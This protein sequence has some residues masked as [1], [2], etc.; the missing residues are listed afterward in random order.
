MEGQSDTTIS[1]ELLQNIQSAVES[2]GL[3]GQVQLIETENGPMTVIIME[4]GAEG[5]GEATVDVS[6]AAGM[7]QPA[8]TEQQQQFQYEVVEDD[9]VSTQYLDTGQQSI[10]DTAVGS[11]VVSMETSSAT[12][13][14]GDTFQQSGVDSDTYFITDTGEIMKI[15]GSMINGSQIQHE[16]TV[17]Q[18]V[19]SVSQFPQEQ[20]FFQT[21]ETSTT[22]E[23]EPRET[24]IQTVDAFGQ[25]VS[26][27]VDTSVPPSVEQTVIQS[28]S[29]G[30]LPQ[31]QSV[32]ETINALNQL[33]QDQGSTQIANTAR[34]Q[35]SVPLA[36]STVLP[37]VVSSTDSPYTA[38]KLS[39]LVLQTPASI[40]SGQ[41]PVQKSLLSG[42]KTSQT[43][44][45]RTGS[46]Q[47]SLA[48]K[49]TATP[50]SVMSASSSPVNPEFST[51]MVKK[52]GNQTILVPTISPTKQTALYPSV[53]KSTPISRSAQ[54]KQPAHKPLMSKQTYTKGT[55]IKPTARVVVDPG[56]KASETASKH[57][58]SQTYAGTSQSI[59]PKPFTYTYTVAG[60]SSS[61]GQTQPVKFPIMRNTSSA[62]IAGAQKPVVLKQP[63]QQVVKTTSSGTTIVTNQFLGKVPEEKS[64]T[65]TVKPQVVG[66]TPE[67]I[68][69]QLTVGE[70]ADL[71]SS[72]MHEAQMQLDEPGAAPDQG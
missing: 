14:G 3:I 17:V 49:S 19:D 54:M 38:V 60:G 57:L 51:F 2:S 43:A 39:D 48:P 55:S 64:V 58:F 50:K 46:S 31:D 25:P 72:A 6:A 71:L 8:V 16:Q 22:Q 18:T 1:A 34:V 42:F 21:I 15:E 20:T 53:P 33:Q 30:Q 70:A 40:A 9:V 28:D 11:S 62:P 7:T 65:K 47:V 35:T 68:S 26:Q 69:K 63:V 10:A 66:K 36:S 61:T 52:I 24:I 59:Q 45:T 27:A 37:S 56:K 44:G 13:E 23:T 32:V 29:V 5:T 67:E 4:E 41:P 12:I